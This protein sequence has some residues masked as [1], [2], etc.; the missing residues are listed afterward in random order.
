LR[1]WWQEIKI[2]SLDSKEMTFTPV[3]RNLVIGLVYFTYVD[4]MQMLL[5][6]LSGLVKVS[7][8]GDTDALAVPRTEVIAA[9]LVV[10]LCQSSRHSSGCL[11]SQEL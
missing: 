10:P 11:L 4:P 5:D 9:D 8:C 2:F 6:P 7:K 3:P 1:R